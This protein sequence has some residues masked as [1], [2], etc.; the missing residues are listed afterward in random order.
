MD[1]IVNLPKVD[2]LKS[3]ILVANRFFKYAPFI[4][5]PHGVSTCQTTRLFFKNVIMLLRIP[6]DI[7]SNGDARFMGNFWIVLFELVGTQLKFSTSNHPQA[8]GQTERR[9]TMLE[10]YLRHYVTANQK[11]WVDL[12]DTSQFCYYLHRSSSTRVSAFQ[13]AASQQPMTRKAG[14]LLLI[15][16]LGAN[17]VD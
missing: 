14:A 9:N 3:I 5:A 16:S 13:F 8:H 17:R 2:G 7:V 12:L 4:L 15:G 1:F 6:L 10:E 11:N